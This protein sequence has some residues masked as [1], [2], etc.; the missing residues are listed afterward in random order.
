MSQKSRQQ[1][2]KLIERWHCGFGEKQELDYLRVKTFKTT[3]EV[4]IGKEQSIVRERKGEKKRIR[5]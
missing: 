4:I 2:P 5:N 3:A 1:F